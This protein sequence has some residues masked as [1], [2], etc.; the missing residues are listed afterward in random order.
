MLRTFRLSIATK[1]LDRMTRWA[2]LQ[3]QSL[4]LRDT[5]RCALPNLGLAE[6]IDRT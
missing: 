4:R 6:Y 3:A 1:S 2:S 5:L